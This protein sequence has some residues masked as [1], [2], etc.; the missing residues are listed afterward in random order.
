MGVKEIGL[1]VEGLGPTNANTGF[2]RKLQA[3][4]RELLREVEGLRGILGSQNSAPLPH[5]EETN[6]RIESGAPHEPWFAYPNIVTRKGLFWCT[7]SQVTL[8]RLQAG[9]RTLLLTFQ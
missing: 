5:I 3:T 9:V 8:V 4:R 7:S 6:P 1:R 2:A